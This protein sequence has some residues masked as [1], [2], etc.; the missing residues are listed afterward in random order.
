MGSDDDRGDYGAEAQCHVL[1][2][3]VHGEG[4]LLQSRLTGQTIQH[5][6]DS[7][8]HRRPRRPVEKNGRPRS[9]G[10]V[11]P[12]ER[13]LRHDLAK[14]D[15]AK[16]HPGAHPIHQHA[17]Q[18][19]DQQA[20]RRP[21]CHQCTDHGK[22]DPPRFMEIDDHERQYQAG[23]QHREEVPGE[24]QPGFAGEPRTHFSAP[25]VEDVLRPSCANGNG[26]SDVGE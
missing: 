18:E 7:A 26:V 1:G 16:H 8:E 13:D 17:A 3:K 11:S 24:E 9:Q 4:A 12:G 19:Y 2:R 20:G 5:C 22:S 6:R 10:V 23:A 14:Q 21:R 25:L 15:H